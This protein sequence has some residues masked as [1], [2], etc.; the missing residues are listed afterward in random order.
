[1]NLDSLPQPGDNFSSKV[2]PSSFAYKLKNIIRYGKYK[3]LQDNYDR[4]VEVVDDYEKYIKKGGIS[5]STYWKMWSKIK[6][7]C[8]GMTKD[9][10]REIKKILQYLKK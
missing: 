2:G 5:Y 9:D 8:V 4:I 3:N 10:E 6:K 7:D 1:M